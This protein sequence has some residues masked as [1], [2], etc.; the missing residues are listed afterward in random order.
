MERNNAPIGWWSDRQGLYSDTYRQDIGRLT[1]KWSTAS[2]RWEGTWGEGK[3]RYGMISIRVLP[4]GSIR[5]AWTTNKD[6]LIRPGVPAL[7]DLEWKAHEE[8]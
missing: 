3:H 6:C 8:K 4:D 2:H 5:G 7:S 1:L